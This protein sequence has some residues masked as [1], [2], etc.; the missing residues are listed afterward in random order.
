M[1]YYHTSEVHLS[2]K[3]VL[4]LLRTDSSLTIVP[5][6]AVGANNLAGLESFNEAPATFNR[7]RYILNKCWTPQSD[8]QQRYRIFDKHWGRRR[9]SS[10]DF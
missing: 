8:V 4:S 6:K 1:T 2:N 3:K 10:H 9:S 7:N 5:E